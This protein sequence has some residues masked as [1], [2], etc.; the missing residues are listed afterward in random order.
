MSRFFSIIVLVF[1]VSACEDFDST[2]IIAPTDFQI[3]AVSLNL[4]GEVLPTNVAAQ[5]VEVDSQ[6]TL[7]G[8]TLRREGKEIVGIWLFDENDPQAIKSINETALTY[9]PFPKQNKL[10]VTSEARNLSAFLRR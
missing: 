10:K 2:K 3:E 4:N 5:K 8:A 7:V 9:S 1:L 6:Y